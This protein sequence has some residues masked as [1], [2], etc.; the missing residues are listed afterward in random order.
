VG[1]IESISGRGVLWKYIRILRNPPRRGRKI[2]F[3]ALDEGEAPDE[4]YDKFGLSR[5]GEMD[6]FDVVKMK[7]LEENS[8]TPILI[9]SVKWEK[10]AKNVYHVLERIVDQKTEKMLRQALSSQALKNDTITVDQIY[11]IV[12]DVVPDQMLEIIN[13]LFAVNRHTT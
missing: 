3:R 5:T 11:D 7:K 4:I 12:R 8:D 1:V 9:E 2:F 6:A 10:S 13:Y